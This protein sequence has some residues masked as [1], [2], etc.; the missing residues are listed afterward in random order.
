MSKS[1]FSLLL[2]PLSH[3]ARSSG[4]SSATP[5]SVPGPPV[6]VAPHVPANWKAG[7]ARAVITPQKWVWMAGIRQPQQTGQ[8]QVPELF[9]KALALKDES[10]KSPCRRHAR[11][12]W[13]SQGPSS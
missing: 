11:P 9:A 8:G 6:S 2:V 10:G 12:D 3:R 1:F 7:V 5:L 4:A 13:R